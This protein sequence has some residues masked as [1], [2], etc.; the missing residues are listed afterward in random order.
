MVIMYHVLQQ[1][2]MEMR[3]GIQIVLTLDL[4]HIFN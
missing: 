4:D 2:A 1:R 3:K